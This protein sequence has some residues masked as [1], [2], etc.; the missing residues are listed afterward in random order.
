MKSLLQKTIV[1]ALL[2]ITIL[3][4]FQCKEPNYP[5]VSEG[6]SNYVLILDKS[7]SEFMME[8]LALFRN[9][10]EQISQYDMLMVESVSNDAI[11]IVI[12]T[13]DSNLNA[14]G[15]LPGSSP[16][17]RTDDFL[18]RNNEEGLTIIGGSEIATF[19]GVVHFL[20]DY[21]GCR[22]Y[23][24]D[25]NFT[26]RQSTIALPYF[27]YRHTPSFEYRDVH[28]P[29]SFDSTW[30]VL[31][32]LTPHHRTVY[33]EEGSKRL[34]HPY[35]HSFFKLVPP[36]DHFDA[37][38]EYY[39][40]V[41]D[42]RTWQNGQLCLSNANVREV[43]SNKLMSWLNSD[44][45]AEYFSIDQMDHG[46]WCECS[47]CRQL[48]EEKN[49]LGGYV[50]DFVDDVSK[51]VQDKYPDA[52][53]TTLAYLNT[54]EAPS[55]DLNTNTT[56]R[57][58]RWG[59]CNAHALDEC[60]HHQSFVNKPSADFRENL[61]KWKNITD[62]LYIWDYH[63]DFS[64][65][66]MPYPNFRSMGGNIGYY[67]NQGVA[68]VFAQG[69]GKDYSQFA[70]MNAWVL[71]RLLWHTDLDA[72]RLREEFCH[73]YYK[74]ASRY[75]LAYLELLDELMN[76]SDAYL[77]PYSGMSALSA[78]FL[79]EGESFLDDAL[80]EV[81]NDSV[82]TARIERELLCHQF[83]QIEKHTEGVKFK[84]VSRKVF[85]K[86]QTHFIHLVNRHQISRFREFNG[87]IKYYLDAS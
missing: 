15:T 13:S 9:Y 70:S 36:R 62:R 39:S 49:G 23:A 71:S 28:Y 5:L 55:I 72:Y 14:S 51:Q 12:T 3:N 33:S 7:E 10:I 59:Y 29:S 77:I 54:E 46:R 6:Q 1:R 26:P 78:S 48:I 87:D 38:P 60:H 11:P 16:L 44:V 45:S 86:V 53:F 67:R 66:L 56:I 21:L 73:A 8:V 69:S 68:G 65:Y 76:S 4:L 35:T 19:N 18:I 24:P 30:S 74:E 47:G 52:R 82:L 34:F 57:L 61:Y 75:I 22:W 64:N 81:K 85:D 27:E 63:I 32:H 58:C 83:A 40:L 41:A 79:M 42:K 20:G 80:E 17:L 31:N 25:E 84:N 43:A 2:V 37:H 50:I